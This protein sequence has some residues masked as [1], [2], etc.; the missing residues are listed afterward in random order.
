MQE[1]WKKVYENKRS[2]F[3]VSSEGRC[4]KVVKATGEE[5]ITLGG[6]NIRLHYYQFAG[7]YVHRH[8]ALAFVPNPDNKLC[9]DHIN[10]NTFDNRAVNLRW[11]T[12]QENNSTNHAKIMR[13]VNAWS[14]NH[15]DEVIMAIKGEQ[16][17]LFKNGPKCAEALGV[18]TSFVYN[19]LNSRGTAGKVKGWTIKWISKQ[20]KDAMPF[21]QMLEKEENEHKQAKQH[22]IDEIRAA[23]KAAT[24]RRRE[25]RK[26]EKQELAQQKRKAKAEAKIRKQITKLEERI[27]I[28]KNHIDTTKSRDNIE[29]KIFA[30]ELK[31]RILEEKGI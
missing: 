16:I 28:W 22:K 4:K 9:V 18:S 14:I 24:K 8:V 12:V 21:V 7:D 2:E 25:Q 6:L 27:E 30:L 29:E 11:V 1:K 3:Y 20:S 26:Y 23:Q 17:K 15:H 31:K 10:S 13:S 19:C 5:Q